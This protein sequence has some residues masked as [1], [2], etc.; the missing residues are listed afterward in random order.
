MRVRGSVRVRGG[1]RVRGSVVLLAVGLD[2][3]GEEHE[4]HG[5]DHRDAQLEYGVVAMV[6]TM[7]SNPNPN[8]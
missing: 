1:V 8:P 4:D 3:G 6:F 7:A 2:D 5:E